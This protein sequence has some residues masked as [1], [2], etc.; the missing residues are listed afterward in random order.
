MA[1]PTG[2]GGMDAMANGL[3]LI[4]DGGKTGLCA[5]LSHFGDRPRQGLEVGQNVPQE[6]GNFTVHHAKFTIRSPLNPGNKLS[7][8]KAN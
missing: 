3:K 8:I 1:M 4:A 7:Q 5:I 6:A 2:D